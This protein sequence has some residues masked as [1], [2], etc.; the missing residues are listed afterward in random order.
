M[1]LLSAEI[2]THSTEHWLAILDKADVWC[3]PVLTL[4]ELVNHEGFQELDMTQRT[5]RISGDGAESVE[6]GTTRSPLR[7]DGKVLKS[8]KGA[9]HV[10]E[11]TESIRAEFNV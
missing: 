4:S 9:P 1:N 10:G 2:S 5:T 6:I 11:N 7:I 8:Q 3:A